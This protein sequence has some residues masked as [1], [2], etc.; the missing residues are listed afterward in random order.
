MYW[1]RSGWCSYFRKERPL[2]HIELSIQENIAWIN[3]SQPE[4][5]VNVL[6]EEALK[7]FS[8]TIDQL[9]SSVQVAVVISKKPSVFIAGADINEIQSLKTKEDFSEKI[10]RAYDIFEKMEKSPTSFIAAIHGACLG[11]GLELALACDYRIATNDPS[12]KIGFPEVN[13]GLVPGFGGTVRLPRLVGFLKSMELIVQ[14]S[15]LSAKKAHKIGLVHQVEN[16]PSLLNES[17]QSLAQQIISGQKKKKTLGSAPQNLESIFKHFISFVFKKQVMKKTKGFYPAPLRAISLLKK[18]YSWSLP[19]ALAEEKK[20]FCDLAVTEESRHLVRLFF[21]ME[22]S[23]KKGGGSPVKKPIQSVGVLGAGVMGSGIAYTTADRGFSVRLQD[24]QKESLVKAQKLMSGL[25][26]KQKKRRKLTSFEMELR[27]SRV[28]YSL[29]QT[30]F[31]TA[32]LVIEAVV[33]NMEVKKQ[34]IQKYFD[35]LKDS[36]IFASNTSSLS[37]NQMASFCKDPSRFVGLHFFNP[38]YRMPLVE[39]IQGER[40]SDETVNRVLQFAKKIGKTPVLVKD[41]PGFL[42]NRLLMPWLSESLWLLASGLKV[43]A[44]DGLFLKFGWPMGPFRLMDEV[45]LDVCV[46]VIQS[47]QSQ[48]LKIDTPPFVDQIAKKGSLGKKDFKGFYHYT[49]KGQS[50]SVNS[51]LERLSQSLKPSISPEEALKKGIYR[52]INEAAMVLEEGVVQ[53]PSEVDTAMILGAGFPPFRG[54][55]LR[56]ADSLGIKSILENLERWENQGETR[57]TPSPLLKK[58]ILHRQSFYS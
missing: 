36:S 16:I 31:S 1:R 12:T 55:L 38:V 49:D 15:S 4:S 40:T 21:L 51:D 29:D 35:C 18:T 8:R 48:G 37:V 14:G 20:T 22:E 30:G 13:L 32:D 3:W 41:R 19:Q 54:G 5:K 50:R 17:A 57:F 39:V 11:G 9:P 58:K 6:S 23:K 56:Y 27:K 45:G 10:S 28:S 7:E 34:V 52:M 26:N 33:E 2:K 24:I 53:E 46:S 47:F 44:L 43:R 42:V 25:W